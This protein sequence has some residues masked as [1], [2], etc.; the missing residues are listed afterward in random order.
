MTHKIFRRPPC[1]PAP[2]AFAALLALA[3][4][5]V[6]PDFQPPAPPTIA[7]ASHPYTPAPLPA[8][9]ASAP[10]A[11]GTPQVFVDGQDIPAAWWDAFHS[12]ALDELVRAAIAHSPTLAA[13]Q[14]TLREAQANYEADYGAKMLPS[15]A[16]QVGG[17]RQKVALGAI[18]GAPTGTA[19]NVFSAQVD[20]SYTVDLF[21]ANRRELEGLAAQIDYQRFQVEAAYLS[22]SSNVV[23]T[24]IQEAAL[25]EQ[26]QATQ[27]VVDAEQKSLDLID[28]Q[29]QLGAVAR[30]AVLQQRT[31]VAQTQAQLPALDKQLAQTRH[32]LA[33]LVGRLPG[34]G[35]LPEFRMDALTLPRELPLSVP[36]ALV[37]QRPDVRASEALLHQASAGIGVATAAL[38]PQITLSGAVDRQSLKLDKLFSM[39]TTGWSLIG[40]LTQPIFNGGAL[41]ARKRAAV[42]AYDA[43]NAQYQETVL[44][45]FLSVANAL[46]AIDIDAEGLRTQAQA[47][48]LAKESLNLVEQQYRLGAASYLASL[49]AQ[50]TWLQTRVALAQ[51]R[52]TRLA[53]TAVLFQ[54]LGGGWWNAPDAVA[55]LDSAAASAPAH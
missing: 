27:E 7:D 38:Y 30:S 34:D 41:H 29:A 42:A 8:R 32:Q 6:G 17:E 23:A 11:T 2:L 31:L 21:G 15:V 1:H 28:R 47:E 52:A 12:P 40:G 14:A 48:S 37:R 20:V 16:G 5:A 54:A 51:A 55:S 22:L 46:R 35:G 43:A 36:S 4:C 24:A 3:G 9:T 50:R 53:D 44:N 33:V 45:A 26:R 25:R 18:G 19:Y 39:G 10:G 13:A 49:D